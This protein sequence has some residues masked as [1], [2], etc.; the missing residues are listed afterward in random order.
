MGIASRRA[1]STGPNGRIQV[2]ERR[3]F[4]TSTLYMGIDIAKWLDTEAER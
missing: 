4:C 2:A 1:R 3:R